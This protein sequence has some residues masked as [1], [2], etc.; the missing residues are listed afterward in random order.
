MPTHTTARERLPIDALASPFVR[1]AR[2]EAAGGILLLAS[3]VAAFLVANSKWG[4][5]YDALL[6]RDFT[7]QLGGF[8]LSLS[9][10]HWLDEGLM[11]IFFFMVGL[12]IKREILVGELSSLRQA[13]FPFAGAVGG[14]VVPALIYLLLTRGTN[15]SHG[16]GVSMATDIAFALGLLTILGNR[17]S[18]SLKVFVT[19][20][21][22]VD[23]II[24]VLVIAVFYTSGVRLTS[25][26]F[27]L[28][29]VAL[30]VCANKLGVRSPSVYAGIGVIIWVAMLS[31]G[32]HAT[33][34]GVLLAMTVPARAYI[35][36]DAFLSRSRSLLTSF[37][38]ADHDSP[39]AH[40]ALHALENHL[41]LVK[42]PLHRIEQA[43]QP[44]VTFLVMPLF[45]FASAGVHINRSVREIVMH[46][47]FLPVVLGL[48]IGKP[49]GVWLFAW[50]SAK[51]RVA[52]RPEGSSWMDL[53]GAACL[54]GI[55][56]TMSL[57]IAS[58]AFAEVDFRDLAKMGA[59]IGS[60]IA[61]A[62]GSAV[63]L[64][65]QN[66]EKASEL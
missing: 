34:A 19:A 15:A 65:P 55:G 54:C 14:S 23:D 26:A 29:G 51:S 22:I 64:R 33:V 43:L 61:G 50:I 21:A 1:F 16:W 20:L 38:G 17:V 25:L 36:R 39:A 57:F 8:T 32:V 28:A 58:L 49:V 46:P 24:A 47:V 5:V 53:L 59:M 35:E 4:G 56:F 60:V 18:G 27:G 48:V 9:F 44:W 11:S 40:Q 42:S 41:Q 6:H 12:E 30:G 45:A 31:S 2:M 10:H 13:A 62:L 7:V 37:E 52:E 66:K 3:T 63:L